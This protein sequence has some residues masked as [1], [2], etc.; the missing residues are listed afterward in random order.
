[1]N[2]QGRTADTHDA[3]AGRHLA[4]VAGPVP[5][6]GDGQPAIP[7]PSDQAPTRQSDAR[8]AKSG[9][10]RREDVPGL[11]L[12]WCLWLLGSWLLVRWHDG[13]SPAQMLGLGEYAGPP[14]TAMDFRWMML[15]AGAGLSGLWPAVRLTQAPMRGRLLDVL[16]QPLVDW[17]SLMI[18]WQ[19]VLWPVYALVPW[20]I[21]QVLWLNAATVGWALLMAAVIG[22]GRLSRATGRRTLAMAGCV[23][24]LLAEPLVIA[25]LTALEPVAPAVAELT[26]RPRVSP[27]AL[28]WGLAAPPGYFQLDPWRWQAVCLIAAAVVAWTG[29]VASSLRR[30]ARD[31]PA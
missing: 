13:M 5:S 20:P 17:L 30:S 19:A 21:E 9:P 22:W 24:L 1:M 11:V 26:W 27:L 29:L 15:A 28:F 18:V 31:A 6:V 10:R 2:S 7:V 4:D 12:M 23:A 8:R 3:S 25:V 14:V 16:V